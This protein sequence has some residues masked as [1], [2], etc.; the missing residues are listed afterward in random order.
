MRP[1][2]SLLL[3]NWEVLKNFMVLTI[4]KVPIIWM[5]SINKNLTFVGAPLRFV[6]KRTSFDFTRLKFLF[7]LKVFS[8][9]LIAPIS[10]KMIIKKI[11]KFISQ[12]HNFR[13]CIFC[14]F[15]YRLGCW[16]LFSISSIWLSLGRLIVYLIGKN[17][18]KL[19]DCRTQE[20]RDGEPFQDVLPLTL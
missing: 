16:L 7:S 18:K 5:L 3:W 6:E 17:M 20:F 19:N 12:I 2:R 10:S 14:L 15:C 11:L 4:S 9:V 8:F 13:I 1:L